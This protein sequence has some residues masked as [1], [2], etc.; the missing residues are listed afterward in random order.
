MAAAMAKK[1]AVE[2]AERRL[3]QC[4]QLMGAAGLKVE[5]GIAR[6]IMAA[7]IASFVDGSTEI[8]T[9]RI[10]RMLAQG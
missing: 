9:D 10:G 2:A 7:K 3:P 4:L 6:H 5:H 1:L 8:Q